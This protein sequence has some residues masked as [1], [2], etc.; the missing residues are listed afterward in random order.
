MFNFKLLLLLFII[1][2]K[3]VHF[4]TSYR[5]FTSENLRIR[6]DSV[7]VHIQHQVIRIK[8]KNAA[9]KLPEMKL[10]CLWSE[11]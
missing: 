8:D 11:R 4:L 3:K 10:H 7:S 2:E 5:K 1:V 9:E 6:S